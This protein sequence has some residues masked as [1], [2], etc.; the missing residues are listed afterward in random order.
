MRFKIL[1]DSF[2]QLKQ[3]YDNFFLKDSSF[4]NHSLIFCKSK[5]K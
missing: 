2:D 3:K 4:L 1:L 5:S